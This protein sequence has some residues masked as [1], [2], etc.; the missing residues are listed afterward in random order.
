MTSSDRLIVQELLGVYVLRSTSSAIDSA[1]SL[2]K[3]GDRERQLLEDPSSLIHP[4]DQRAIDT[5]LDSLSPSDEMAY[6]MMR[7]IV[8]GIDPEKLEVMN[9]Q[10]MELL[11]PYMGNLSSVLPMLQGQ[12]LLKGGGNIAKA[13]PHRFIYRPDTLIQKGWFSDAAD[14]VSDTAGDVWDSGVI[15]GV[16]GAGAVIAG[17]A[18]LVA[19]PW[20]IPVLFAADA[21]NRSQGSKGSIVGEGIKSIGKY[22]VQ[23]AVNA[24]GG[25]L[26]IQTDWGSIGVPGLND[27]AYMGGHFGAYSG[28]VD[29]VLGMRGEMREDVSW[30]DRT[31]H[32]AVG[33]MSGLNPANML[34]AGATGTKFAAASAAKVSGV[35]RLAGKSGAKAT[36]RLGDD[37]AKA[38]EAKYLEDLVSV[39]QVPT[40][41]KGMKPSQASTSHL[42]DSQQAYLAHQKEAARM[43]A[44]SRRTRIADAARNPK[45]AAGK[46]WTKWKPGRV[47]RGFGR[48]AQ[49]F[50]GTTGVDW[51]DA[52]K[53]IATIGA[54]KMP[55][56][57]ANFGAGF[58]SGATGSS[59]GSGF[60]GAAVGGGAAGTAR[61]TGDLGVANKK[62]NISH[63]QQIWEGEEWGGKFGSPQQKGDNMRIGDRMLKEAMDKMD[64]ENKKGKKPAH[65]MVIVISS[66]AGPG[67]SKDGKRQKLDYEKE[68]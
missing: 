21:I 31:K 63:R 26:D 28:Y 46:T 17:V 7:R 4:N 40:P 30:W 60:G 12:S 62:G 18:L 56:A 6:G 27:D 34:R 20:A 8:G 10:F 57:T 32:I 67:P 43:G 58:D 11:D 14:W 66:E 53:V 2:L 33:A 5:Y 13:H 45:A 47:K 9:N 19:F 44:K 23:P 49:S 15:Q 59:M 48:A 68:E 41:P 54:N 16:I 65:G 38:A 42:T 22:I 29:P 3:Q 25:D 55:Q 24:V 36:T 39:G 37:A 52:K 51:Q 64:E 35:G 50:G 1:W 61:M